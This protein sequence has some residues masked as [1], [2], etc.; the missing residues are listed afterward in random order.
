MIDDAHRAGLEVHPYT[1]RPENHF[2][3]K[4]LRGPGADAARHDDG[5]IA[6]MRRFLSAGIDAFF[7]DDPAL[8]RKAVDGRTAR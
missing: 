1:F 4:D 3:P 2:L 7:T 6:E 8:G 5:S